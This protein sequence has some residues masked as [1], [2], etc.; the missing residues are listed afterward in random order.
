M[1]S[2]MEH[3]TLLEISNKTSTAEEF[4]WNPCQNN[5]KSLAQRFAN[6]WLMHVSHVHVQN[7]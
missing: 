1:R 3:N 4:S 5:Y 2:C 6:M 7:N